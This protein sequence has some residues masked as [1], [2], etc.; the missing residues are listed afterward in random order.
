MPGARDGMRINKAMLDGMS[1]LVRFLSAT[2]NAPP[3]SGFEVFANDSPHDQYAIPLDRLWQDI[4]FGLRTLR[5][6]F[7][8]ASTVILTLAIGIGVNTA[9]FSVVRS[10]ILE[11]LPY[12]DPDR[13]VMVWSEIP[14]EQVL[15]ASSSF[16][17][18]ED[19]RAQN[20]VFENL[21][22]ID[23]TTLTLSE[24]EWPEQVSTAKVSANF[25]ETLGVEPAFGRVFSEEEESLSSNLV[26]LSHAAWERRFGSSPGAIGRTIQLGGATFQV[27]GVMPEKFGMRDE[28]TEMWLPRTSLAGPV[29][30]AGPRGTGPL[31]V[32]GRLNPGVTI[33][34]AREEMNLIAARLEQEYPVANAG[35]RINV[36]SLHDQVTGQSFRLALWTLFG[37]VGVV[38]LIACANGAHMILARG[39]SRSHEVALRLSLG[40]TRGRLIRQ[41]LTESLLLSGL[42]GVAGVF[43]AMG[44]LELLI[45]F[46]PAGIPRLAEMSIDAT[47]LAYATLVSL[48]VGIIFGV[49]PAVAHSSGS[50]FGSLREGR[51]GSRKSSGHKARRL[52]IVFQFALA[53]VLVFGAGLLIRS[54]AE[55]R[56]IDLGFDSENVLVANLSV[57]AE[58]R[59]V[60]FY[61]EVIR[62]VDEVP[63]VE[64]S[65]LVEDLFISGA[66]NRVLTV[67]GGSTTEPVTAELRID[68]IAGDFF[69]TI[70]VPLRSGRLFSAVD[71]ADGVPVAIINETMAKR[72]WPGESP[73]GKRFRADGQLWIEVVGVVGDMR[74]QGP[75]KPP[76]SQVFVPFAQAPSRNMI[77]LV[78]GGDDVSGL[79]DAIRTRIAAL[80]RTVPLYGISTLDAANDR[81]LAQRRFQAFMVG[82]FST[83][84][85]VLAAIGIYGLIQYTVSQRTRE[86]G[87]RMAL[88]GTSSDVLAMIV[89]Q[90]LAVALPGLALGIIGAFFVSRALSALFFGVSATDLTNVAITSVI[91]L[92]TTLIACYIPARRAAR[93][94]PMST[95]R[96]V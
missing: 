85:L 23:P 91:L 56:G 29:D 71:R 75:E 82:L 39:M 2:P 90:G 88:G 42:A 24:G 63:T 33:E 27:I 36:V 79:T 49:A 41:A 50:L 43:F 68:A 12:D 14:G 9:V 11:P 48:L 77:L 46:A 44:C 93:V 1:E 47:V 20:R 15:E 28:G 86:I 76:I 3:L 35:L 94:D 81:Y 57:Q 65:A 5:R 58:E 53:I 89:R 40:A 19:W 66:P 16:A 67:E 17:N 55:A 69:Q 21:A 73:I 95:L 83:I 8:F 45:A 92:L 38:L 60:P 96:S 37:A 72:F 70:G 32:V 18:I 6:D 13:L 51:G 64:S 10:V 31:E 59:R 87:V 62:T 25:F 52:L 74:R 78:K 84:A 7:G 4:R 34:R 26:V 30:G 80:D 22:T 61:T 54:L